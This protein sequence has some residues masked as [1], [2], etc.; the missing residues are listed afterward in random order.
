MLHTCKNFRY[1]DTLEHVLLQCEALS[2]D[3]RRLASFMLDQ[4]ADFPT[5]REIITNFLTSEDDEMKMQFLIDCST[6]PTV[7]QAVQEGGTAIL[8][9][10]FKIT[11]TW[12]RSIHVSR[13]R[14]MRQVSV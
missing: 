4:S 13:S 5:L 12:C 10:C 7:I 2:D 1:L 3:R 6:L 9:Q 14:K 8:N 11:R